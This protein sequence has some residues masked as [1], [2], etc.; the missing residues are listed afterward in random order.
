MLYAVICT[1]MPDSA[2]IR[3]DNREDHL[4]YLAELGRKVRAAGPFTTE[5]GEAMNGSLLILE[6][7]SREEASTMAG[8]DP[9]ARAGL[10]ATVEIRPWRWTITD[11]KRQ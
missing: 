7:E 11:G 2:H 5:D 4:A 9:Y 6:A 1:D 3:A 10:F 8:S